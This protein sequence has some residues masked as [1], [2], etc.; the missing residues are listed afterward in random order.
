MTDEE[1]FKEF[2]VNKLL[3]IWYEQQHIYKISNE[4]TDSMPRERETKR[5]QKIY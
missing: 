5:R 2:I 4:K 3:Y 1:L